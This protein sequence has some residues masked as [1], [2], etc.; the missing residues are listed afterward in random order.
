MSDPK[1]MTG[2]PLPQRANQAVG[3]PTGAC[4]MAEAVLLQDARDVGRGLDLLLPE[5]GEGEDLVDH[6]LGQLGALQ[7]ARFHAFHEGLE[8]VVGE[9][10]GGQGGGG[11]EEGGCGGRDG[12]EGGQRQ[13]GDG[14]DWSLRGL[15]QEERGEEF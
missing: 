13:G 12:E 14:F 4:S 5:F 11:G 7:D 1:E 6:H 9:A 2:S 15:D 8:L 10:L 3:M